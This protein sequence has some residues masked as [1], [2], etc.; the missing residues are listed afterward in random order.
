MFDINSENYEIFPREI[1]K[2]LNKWK[3]IHFNR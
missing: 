3:D 1:L 2:E